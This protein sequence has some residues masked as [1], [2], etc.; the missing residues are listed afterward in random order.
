MVVSYTNV[1]RR[2]VSI[3][4]W[5][6]QSIEIVGE[7]K[8]KKKKLKGS[9]VSRSPDI[10]NFDIQCRSNGIH[11]RFLCLWSNC[12]SI[13]RF[14]TNDHEWEGTGS[15]GCQRDSSYCEFCNKRYGVKHHIVPIDGPWRVVEGSMYGLSGKSHQWHHRKKAIKP[16]INKTSMVSHDKPSY[17]SDK[18][19][20]ISHQIAL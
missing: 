4:S 14:L 10:L 18:T 11:C 5:A 9:A 13:K 7:R 17:I 19:A 15:C 6:V 1:I 3:H 12:G 20:R 16:G 2:W 8:K